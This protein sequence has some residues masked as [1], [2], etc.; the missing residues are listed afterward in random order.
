MTILTAWTRSNDLL[1]RAL[2][3]NSKEMMWWNSDS[4][5]EGLKVD[6]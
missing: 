4:R 5:S 3:K 2:Q 1:D 6:Y